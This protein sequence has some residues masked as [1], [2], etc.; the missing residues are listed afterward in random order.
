V[1]M[2]GKYILTGLCCW[3][4]LGSTFA[5]VQD[6]AEQ[7]SIL[8]HYAGRVVERFGQSPLFITILYVVILYSIVTLITLLVIILLNRKR[9][10]R[11]EELREYLKQEYQ[12]R[13][14]DYLFDERSRERS[15]RE[16][17]EIASGRF[18]R[19][20]LIDQMI[21]LSINLKGQIKDLIKNLYLTLGLKKDSLEKA[22]SRKWHENV[23]GFREL[24]YMNIREAND[25]IIESL[26]S[27]NE[28]LRMEAQIALVRLSDENPY[29]FLHYMKR[30]L[31]KWEQITLHEMLIQHNL[32]VPEFRQWF[33]SENLTV[34]M[35]A[36]EMAS[37]FR[38][39][40]AGRDIIR[41]LQHEN[42]QVRY[43]A[44]RVCGE[45][46]LKGSLPVLK[47]M[48]AG[49]SYKNKLEILRTFARI[50]DARY[51]NF[52]KSVLDMED[53]VQLQIQATKAMENTD[54]P[55]V[56]MLVKLMKSKSGYRNYQIIIRH[57]LDGRIY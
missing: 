48:Y 9:I 53:D 32:K 26:N 46:N 35:F 13:I 3:L 22:C 45:M 42:E 14:M 23:K 12:Q 39:K 28:I 11:E 56:S 2:T 5:M 30:P 54:E 21:D 29:H 36:L 33:E 52:L 17:Q 38:Q 16:L 37:W 19:Q 25:R 8:K 24:A 44:I 6:W 10:H 41:L 20:I 18:N 4:L 7:E 50:P 57:V 15:I 40:S 34:L 1:K 27:H 55:G 47:K 51:L 49:E 43:T 31:A